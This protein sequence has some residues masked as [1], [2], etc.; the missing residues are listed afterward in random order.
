MIGMVIAFLIVGVILQS[1]IDALS[2]PSED[3]KST[4]SSQKR[5]PQQRIS[6]RA[7]A[8][9]TP[10]WPQKRYISP[11]AQ[12]AWVSQQRSLNRSSQNLHRHCGGQ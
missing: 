9:Q 6:D 3:K 5:F 8:P 4:P 7:I 11:G 10:L 12:A 2:E 1:I